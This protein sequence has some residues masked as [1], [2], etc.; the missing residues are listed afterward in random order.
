MK[1]IVVLLT[2][3]TCSFYNVHCQDFKVNS[4]IS[5]GL[6]RKE[7]LGKLIPIY[8]KWLESFK[9]E[10]VEVL[11][12]LY[13]NRAVM[14]RSSSHESLDSRVLSGRKEIADDFRSYFEIVSSTTKLQIDIFDLWRVE[15]QIVE[16]GSWLIEYVDNHRRHERKGQYIKIWILD[17]EGSYKIMK[18]VNLPFAL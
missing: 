16:S 7:M 18:E 9:A 15:N 17:N 8:E 1:I 4:G 10:K 14:L 11:A 3:A 5:G 6:E 12:Q 2:V 13:D